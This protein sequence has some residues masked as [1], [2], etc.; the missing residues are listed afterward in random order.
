MSLIN[1]ETGETAFEDKQLNAVN[2]QLIEQIEKLKRDNASKNMLIA[3]LKKESAEAVEEREEAEKK[4][5]A[6]EQ[7]LVKQKKQ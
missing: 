4:R 1:R 7:E 3:Q 6:V 5:E 2:K